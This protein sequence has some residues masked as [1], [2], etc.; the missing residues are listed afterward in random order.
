[1]KKNQFKIERICKDSY[2][3]YLDMNYSQIEN[4]FREFE[5]NRNKVRIT[6]E[7]KGMTFKLFKSKKLVAL[8]SNEKQI[9]DLLSELF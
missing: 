8:A 4:V 7:I 2:S 6:Y 9:S 5:V 3:I 1:M